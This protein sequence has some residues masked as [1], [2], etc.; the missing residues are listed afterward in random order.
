M[1]EPVLLALLYIMGCMQNLRRIYIA[2]AR[3]I[4]NLVTSKIFCLLD[5]PYISYHLFRV[6]DLNRGDRHLYLL[7]SGRDAT[8]GPV[9]FLPLR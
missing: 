8:K 2:F 5:L 7:A 4:P 6:N 1:K 3:I 9:S